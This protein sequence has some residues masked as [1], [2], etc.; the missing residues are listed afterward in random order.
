M[1]PV[2]LSMKHASGFKN[3]IYNRFFDILLS[4]QCLSIA[5]GDVPMQ[6]DD[7]TVNRNF[8]RQVVGISVEIGNDLFCRGSSA[9]AP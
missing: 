3:S 2:F 8:V 1:G 4:Q 7:I 6:D 9:V 5:E